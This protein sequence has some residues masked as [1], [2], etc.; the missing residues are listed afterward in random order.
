MYV[1]LQ[2]LFE[3]GEGC[4]QPKDNERDSTRRAS[5]TFLQ[6][7]NKADSGNRQAAASIMEAGIR[8]KALQAHMVFADIKQLYG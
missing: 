2:F 1:A 4:C 6:A 5:D 7:K 3:F 8:Q